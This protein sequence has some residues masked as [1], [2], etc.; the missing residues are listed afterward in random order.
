M[1]E[2]M[3]KNKDGA[4]LCPFN[5][6]NKCPFMWWCTHSNQWKEYEGSEHCGLAAKFMGEGWFPVIKRVDNTL[7]LAN[8]PQDP[9]K[10]TYT[11][12]GTPAAIKFA[13][14]GTIA[15]ALCEQ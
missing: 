15:E 10:I 5:N 2:Y 7:Y 13:P 4:V 12:E 3:Y 9:L 6:F 1:C 8:G 14:D 11:G